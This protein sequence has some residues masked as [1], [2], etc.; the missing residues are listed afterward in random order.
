MALVEHNHMIEQVPSATANQALRYSILPRAL[1]ARSF[2]LYA[3]AL[4]RVHNFVI[5]VRPVVEDEVS[6]RGVVGKASRNCWITQALVGC[7]VTRKCRIR[8]RSCAMTKKQYSTP[9]V[10]VGTVKKSIAA[11]AS[12][13]LLKKAAHRLAGSGLRGALCIHRRTVLSE[14][15]NPSIFISPWIRGAPQVGLSATIRKISSRS[16]FDVGFLPD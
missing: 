8:R 2:G 11:I 13:W 15:S 14:M 10:I 12:R 9:K 16:G 6:R 5:E 7:L 4:D 3:E 1:E